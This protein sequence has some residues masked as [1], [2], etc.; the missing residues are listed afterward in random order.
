MLRASKEL[1]CH[2]FRGA[3]PSL[4]QGE[5]AR[6]GC[7][8]VGLRTYC[9]PQSVLL[10]RRRQI[11]QISRSGGNGEVIARNLMWI[12][13]ETVSETQQRYDVDSITSV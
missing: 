2:N 6:G 1:L 8:H 9:V 4:A 3:A 12:L 13:D 5:A 10:R 7:A 11:Q